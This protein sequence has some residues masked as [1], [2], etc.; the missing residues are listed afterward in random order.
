MD[1]KSAFARGLSPFLFASSLSA[2]A[3]AARPG[4]DLIGLWGSEVPIGPQIRGEI[5]LERGT[6]RWTVRVAGFE[7]S[8]AITG[9]SIR[10]TLPGGQGLLRARID[11]SATAIR[12][13]WVQ[14]AGVF[15]SYATPVRLV[16]RRDGSWIGTVN[17]IDER[18]SFYL[19]VQRQADGTLKGVFRNPEINWNGRAPWFRVARDGDNV[20]FINP[21]SGKKRW[22]QSYD[23]AQRQIAFDFGGPVVLRPRDPDQ[24][25]GFFPRS[26]SAP[27]YV[28]RVPVSRDDGWQSAS[29][30][31]AG[32]DQV[33][34]QSLVRR[35]IATDPS[36][37]SA[38]LIHSLLIARH[39]RLVL[40]EYFSGQSSDLPHDLRSASKT[41]TSVMAGVAMDH[42]ARFTMSSSVISLLPG[43][44]ALPVDDDRKARITVGHLLTHSTGLACDD[45]DDTSPGNEDAMQSQSAEPDWYR[46]VLG[47][48][49]AHDPGSTYAYCSGG[50]NLVG[51]V[52]RHTTRMWL[53]DFFD[54]YIARPLQITHYGMNLMP[55]GDAYAGG[56]VH[57]RSRDLLKFGQLYL[58]G[59]LWNG[60][61]VVSANWV[62]RSTA[63]QIN[64]PNGTSDGYGW[65]RYTLT[66]GG[67]AYQ[68]YEANGNGGQFLIVVPALDLTVVFTA[69]N[70]NQYR[71]WRTL[72]D[73]LVPQYILRGAAER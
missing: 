48:S 12:G 55:S 56:G 41:F 36:S 64:A 44:V 33:Q 27:L 18:F 19:Q 38:P 10:V 9:D 6:N 22:V 5:V 40:E 63:H 3:V 23:S 35:V 73:E 30:A 50:I 1:V 26:P 72:R 7:A 57:M 4:D 43:K 11:A 14:P 24:M 69:G 37:D 17:P 51:G 59:G 49:M 71:I 42:G 62:A 52:I 29:A 34:L 8:A 47:L 66:V 2:Q 15:S 39:G 65:H 32:L 31:S 28:Y 25:V 61:R 46:Y 58:N 68:E 54:R 13:F 70:Y 60:T 53:P 45:N 21:A 16:H 20:A 67:K